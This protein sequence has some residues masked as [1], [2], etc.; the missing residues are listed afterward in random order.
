MSHCS[1]CLFIVS[2]CASLSQEGSAP[3]SYRS[4]ED[5]WGFPKAKP[6]KNK[7]RRRPKGRTMIATDTPERNELQIKRK[8][9][10]TKGP[11]PKRAL[12]LDDD[13]DA[14]ESE[15][16]LQDSSDDENCDLTQLIP[17]PEFVDFEDLERPPTT[18][19]FV[20]VEFATK[21][22]IYFVGKILS[23]EEESSECEVTFLRK[24]LKLENKFVMPLVP[25]V[26]F[27]NKKC[28]KML[29]P[30]PTTALGK[31]KRQQSA[32][33]FEINFASYDVR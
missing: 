33:S 2:L 27:I 16:I 6:R 19:D 20:L 32:V 31:T 12:F 25:D 15:L 3:K 21:N 23:I 22:K 13:T 5:I 24:S 17:E 10:D 1:H 18:G 29:L 8:R 4:P 9:K 14:D 30:N 28:I 7:S 11:K 26:S